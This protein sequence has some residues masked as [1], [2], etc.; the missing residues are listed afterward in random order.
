MRSAFMLL[1]A[2]LLLLEPRAGFAQEPPS[3]S[4][5]GGF[6]WTFGGGLAAPVFDSSKRFPLGGQFDVALGYRLLDRLAVQVDYLYSTYGVSAD[7][8]QGGS[9]NASHTVQAGNLNFL[10][11]VLPRSSSVEL[12]VLGGPGVYG[13]TVEV[14]SVSGEPVPSLCEPGLLLCF[15]SVAPFPTTLAKATEIGFGLD[16][17]LGMSISLGIPVRLFLETRFHFIWGTIDT[18]DGPRKANGQYVPVSI[19]FRYF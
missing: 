7:V 6:T 16:A 3:D 13:R 4:P 10:L 5:F 1:S 17:G 14:S 8:L 18:P 2:A 19:G 15:S 11:S 12:Y 9:F